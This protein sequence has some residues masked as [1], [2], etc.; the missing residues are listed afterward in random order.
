MIRSPG[1]LEDQDFFQMPA[2]KKYPKKLQAV[3]NQKNNYNKK[4]IINCYDKDPSSTKKYFLW[5]YKHNG[6][7]KSYSNCLKLLEK[8][9]KY[10]SKLPENQRDINSWSYFDLLDHFKTHEDSYKLL[11]NRQKKKNIFEKETIKLNIKYKDYEYYIP[12]TYNSMKLLSMSTKW[13]ISNEHTYNDYIHCYNYIFIVAVKEKEDKKL[14]ICLKINASINSIYNQLDHELYNEND[15]KKHLEKNISSIIEQIENKEK[16]VQ[17]TKPIKSLLLYNNI[18]TKNKNNEQ[19]NLDDKFI[20]EN[21]EI[22]ELITKQSNIKFINCLNIDS[23]MNLLKCKKT[24]Y[25]VSDILIH[26]SLSMD[27]KL[28]LE[29]ANKMIEDCLKNKKY[30]NVISKLSQIY[31]YSN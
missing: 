12:L 23:I 25:S 15:I 17:F 9:E 6:E 3:L 31:Y 18:I 28:R 26:N 24:K 8:F 13:C 16:E 22:L 1:C 27:G 5:I 2:E 10:Q 20:T 14:C 29:L 7:Y 30:D 21:G 11:S 19:I 4:I